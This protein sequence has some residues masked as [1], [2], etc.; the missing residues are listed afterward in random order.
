MMA[1]ILSFFTHPLW[2]ITFG[3]FIYLK[4]DPYA[5]G[6]YDW[7][8]RIPFVI[9]VFMMTFF[10][11]A[12]VIF[13][14]LKLDFI[15]SIELHTARERIIPYIATSIFYLWLY[16]TTRSNPEIAALF[17]IFVLGT[18]ITLFLIFFINNF[19]KA[20]AHMAGL[21]GLLILTIALAYRLGPNDGL[22]WL[23]SRPSNLPSMV[24][25][26]AGLTGSARLKLEAHTWQE[27]LGGFFIGLLGQLIALKI[28]F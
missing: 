10:F 16:I 23:T 7:T 26:I 2:M 14:L 19:S 8:L 28:Y 4:L 12:L 9:T 1:R 3:L 24:V 25:L 27:L 17:K 6:V 20:S 13:L 22:G 15:K 21:A 11:P 18:V 5:F